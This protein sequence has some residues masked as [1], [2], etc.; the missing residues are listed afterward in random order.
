MEASALDDTSAADVSHISRASADNLVRRRNSESPVKTSRSASAV[1]RKPAPEVKQD[2]IDSSSSTPVYGKTYCTLEVDDSPRGGSPASSY[3]A[4][5]ASQTGSDSEPDMV[6][7]ILADSQSSTSP[8]APTGRRQSDPGQIVGL[9]LVGART[10]SIDASIPSNHARRGA[11]TQPRAAPSKSV[12]AKQ[13]LASTSSPLIG[14]ARRSPGTHSIADIADRPWSLISAGEADTPILKLRELFVNTNASEKGSDEDHNHHGLF[15]RP[16]TGA[17]KQANVDTEAIAADK[18]EATS[19]AGSEHLESSSQTTTHSDTKHEMTSSRSSRSSA[20]H[21]AR[22]LAAQHKAIDLSAI[23]DAPSEASPASTIRARHVS[24]TL[25]QLFDQPGRDADRDADS[26]GPLPTRGR[27]HRLEGSTGSTYS[28]LT[29]RQ[30]QRAST[31]SRM[32]ARSS[33][34]WSES[35]FSEDASSVLEAEVGQARRTE[36]IAL[37]KGRVQDWVGDGFARRMIPTAEAPTLSRSNTLPK[38][39]A[40]TRVD[41]RET[42]RQQKL[43]DQLSRKLQQL[44]D[45]QVET[46]S[47][48]EPM[49]DH[50]V[51][52]GDS[53]AASLAKLQAPSAPV[54]TESADH[55]A[56]RLIRS[57]SSRSA[58]LSA[59]HDRQSTGPA[60]QPIMASSVPAAVSPSPSFVPLLSA[61]NLTPPKEAAPA[62][63]V[64]S[65]E[66]ESAKKESKSQRTPR[67]YATSDEA[68]RAK[69]HEL[70]KK[71]QRLAE[72]ERRRQA[73]MQDK[74]AKKKQSD[75]LL[76]A[77][78]ALMG[79]E[80][81]EA[82]PQVQTTSEA[83]LPTSVSKTSVSR[84]KL[85]RPPVPERRVSSQS[86]AHLSVAP[87]ALMRNDWDN[88]SVT[89]FHTA[90]DATVPDPA[91]QEEGT[92][93]G[94][95][96]R[97]DRS[98]S[99]ESSLA[100]DF[101]FPAPPQ[102]I[103]EQASDDD[104]LLGHAGSPKS[105]RQDG[106][107]A[108]STMPA[109]SSLL[110]AQSMPLR[111]SRSTEYSSRDL[112]KLAREQMM[113]EVIAH[114]SPK[115]L[116]RQLQGSPPRGL[117]IELAADSKR[118]SSGTA[119]PTGMVAAPMHAIAA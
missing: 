45:A 82:I 75:P 119:T 49:V 12:T 116:R 5:N 85:A 74:Y 48:P 78:L 95:T 105:R 57:L 108:S 92:D 73:E 70:L 103:K 71:E 90:I 21:A 61:L 67:S 58:R 30:A 117:G 112:R 14:G 47:A 46:H 66:E 2:E 77:R 15:F 13:K 38:K 42:Q 52:V 32:T 100:E 115:S 34:H 56:S 109:L 93:E 33:G 107:S 9:G 114:P 26:V 16:L 110:A 11:G 31:A 86:R 29:P 111:R 65:K 53:R 84:T 40:A 54:K 28:Q 80:P 98:S 102:R 59:F 35:R 39:L 23:S 63:P 50:S 72:K 25:G 101:D 6:K 118:Y 44:S 113:Q 62:R 69:Q 1:R 79:L 94:R 27:Q 7:E 83:M 51:R 99:L 106:M 24:P 97:A 18:L 36:V 88:V 17:D 10:G 55:F 87:P 89:S 19:E 22:A 96:E 37:G 41:G 3:R 91:Q 8:D 104:T 64:D 20:T 81:A 76:A 60:E 4:R 43:N 68:A